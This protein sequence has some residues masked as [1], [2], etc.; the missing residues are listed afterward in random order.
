MSKIVLTQVGTPVTPDA[1]T[2]VIYVK[3]GDRLYLKK[4]SGIEVPIS[5]SGDMP[6]LHS[7]THLRTG[8]DP[9][10][11]ATTSV[12][13]I[14]VLATDGETTSGEVVQAQDTRINNYQVNV[15]NPL[16][17]CAFDGQAPYN[18][19]FEGNAVSNNL[20]APTTNTAIFRPGKFGKAVQVAEATTNLA[21]N[22]SFEVDLS[23]W[24]YTAG[25][26]RTSEKS[27]YGSYAAKCLGASA[28][29]LIQASVAVSSGTTYTASAYVYLADAGT[30][31]MDEGDKAY[32]VQV[33]TSTTGQWVR[34]VST[35]TPTT[36]ETINIR[37][38]SDTCD[39]YVD[40]FQL[41]AKAYATSYCDGSLGINHSWSGTAHASASART[42]QGLIF[43]NP[44]IGFANKSFSISLWLYSTC[45]P[46]S[47][48]A[49]ILEHRES[50]NIDKKL[51]LVVRYKVPRFC[52]YGDDLT[53][54]STLQEN[55]WVHL[56]FTYDATTRARK[57]YVN[58]SLDASDVSAGAFSGIATTT[59]LGLYGAAYL[60]GCMDDLLFTD[61]VLTA[62]QIKA[63]YDSGMP[64][65]VDNKIEITDWKDFVPT[66][67]QN[68]SISMSAYTAK[69]RYVGKSLEIIFMGTV[70]GTGTDGQ[71]V[72]L[73]LPDYMPLCSPNTAGI[74]LGVMCH[75]NSGKF[76]NGMASYYTTRSICGYGN[77]G[78]RITAQLQS[79]HKVYVKASYPVT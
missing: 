39:F 44:P 64:W 74:P 66:L 35:F 20:I 27:L 5:F 54:S 50:D 63:Y 40:G 77:D 31:Y 53:G 37:V 16:L 72:Q 38:F 48:D 52:F 75:Y 57:I 15:N 1:G 36:S 56:A 25:V 7:S 18:T 11:L 19:N 59:V 30:V 9:L 10:S 61:T 46:A 79:G 6:T 23:N 68:G 2:D 28:L 12:A 76:N 47:G 26:S 4:S 29:A 17:Y 67:Y 49:G 78:N 22:P 69:Y 62:T 8:S 45:F 24:T 33:E 13:G 32:E 3:S 14:T 41:E 34:L 70:S 60:N 73:I 71:V 43:P 58:G 55:T 21:L 51:H 65:R 42:A